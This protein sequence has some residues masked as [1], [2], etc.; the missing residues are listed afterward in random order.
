M[1]EELCNI[2][3][4]YLDADTILNLDSKSSF[5]QIRKRITVKHIK[6]PL[7]EDFHIN[8]VFDDRWHSC[9]I[10]SLNSYDGMKFIPI[11]DDKYY[12]LCS[13]TNSLE[14]G[15]AKY[16]HPGIYTHL[17]F[18]AKEIVNGIRI[19]NYLLSNRQLIYS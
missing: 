6:S 17:N 9:R 11:S 4:D 1:I 18:H 10:P 8:F 2:I 3:Y 13:Y 16:L 19:K 14:S 12:Y 7:P 5:D 15:I